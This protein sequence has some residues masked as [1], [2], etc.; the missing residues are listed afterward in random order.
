MLSPLLIYFLFPLEF[1]NYFEYIFS[2]SIIL[3]Q[4]I[5]FGSEKYQFYSYSNS[6]NK[7]NHYL[8]LVYI[9]KSF[10]ILLSSFLFFFGLILFNIYNLDFFLFIF[11]IFS[12]SLFL[13][14]VRYFSNLF[15]ILDFPEKI[16]YYSIPFNILALF[17]III[18]YH[19]FNIELISVYF[20]FLYLFCLYFCF[21]NI[22]KYE[23]TSVFDYFNKAIKFS[24]PL[25]INT[26]ILL[27]IANFGKIFTF[28]YLSAN[29]MTLLSITQRICLIITFIHIAFMGYYSKSIFIDSKFII[30]KNIILKYFISIATFSLISFLIF[31][32][33]K[34]INFIKIEILFNDYIKLATYS[35]FFQIGFSIQ[36]FLEIYFN[37]SNTNKN[38]LAA[39]LI[40]LILYSILFNLFSLS[41]LNILIIMNVSVYSG[42]LYLMFKLYNL[43]F[44]IL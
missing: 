37:R 8:K 30:K 3:T 21:S 9:Y 23:I 33:L 18:P 36:S 10:F 31:I 38:I 29:E 2:I 27:F 24:W 14:S 32:I 6:K 17:S 20:I 19:F 16:F 5:G 42:V 7:D 26:I 11:F 35:I 34:Y 43:K 13:Y 1:Y 44:K 28:H 22:L 15:R 41:L 40:C 12:R 4:F 39:N 25:L